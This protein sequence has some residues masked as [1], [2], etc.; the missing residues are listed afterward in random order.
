[1]SAIKTPTYNL[2]KF[3]VPSFELASEITDQDPGLFIV[4]LDVESLFTNIPLDET[5]S[6]CY[7]SLF[8]KNVKVNNIN[9]IDFEK[10]LKAALQNNFFNF[11]EKIQK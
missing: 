8:S 1:M 3:L 7:D 5:I 11:E 2:A 9:R 6:E 10:N 4:S